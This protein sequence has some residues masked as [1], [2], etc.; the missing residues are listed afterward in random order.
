MLPTAGQKRCVSS[1]H[2]SA[3]LMDVTAGLVDIL[4]KFNIWE[5]LKSDQ[6]METFMASPF[7]KKYKQDHE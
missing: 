1:R 4:S 5:F 7:E 6:C 3:P 2:F